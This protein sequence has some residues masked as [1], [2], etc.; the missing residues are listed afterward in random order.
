MPSTIH[1]TPE[2]IKACEEIWRDGF[3]K[4][5]NGE[6][7]LPDFKV[8]FNDTNTKL[9]EEPS[10]EELEKLPFNPS[11]C[12]ARVEKFGF[13]IQCTRTPFGSGCLCKIHQNMLDKFIYYLLGLLASTN[14]TKNFHEFF[15]T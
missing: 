11:K 14:C 12:E 10:Y 1:F 15:L 6:D 8:F 4:G 13:A 5:V 3:N 7:E 2:F 9:K